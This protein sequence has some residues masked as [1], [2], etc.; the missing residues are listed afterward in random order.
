MKHIKQ[1]IFSSD[2]LK[3]SIEQKV[4][5][6]RKDQTQ[7]IWHWGLLTLFTLL[8]YAS[9][10][11]QVLLIL[12]LIA[13]TAFIKGPLMLI[14]GSLY[15]ALIAF[16]PP[17]ALLL[18]VLFFILNIGAAIKNWRITLVGVF[19]YLYPLMARLGQAL[20]SLDSRWLTLVLVLIG[21]TAFHFMLKWL[22]QYSFISRS[23]AGAI[24][25]MPYSLFLVFLPKKIRG[26]RK[27]KKINS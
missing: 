1:T 16:F 27:S 19:F 23:L 8:V 10:T 25:S 14:W 13:L 4:I 9:I 17:I 12:F 21:I 3:S 20:L 2:L 5:S 6:R 15:S 7:T 26:L 22:Y 18:S 11:H 24:I